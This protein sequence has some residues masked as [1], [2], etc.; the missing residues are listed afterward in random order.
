LASRAFHALVNKSTNNLTQ[1]G[2]A[3]RK[4]L[5]KASLH[6][7]DVTLAIVVFDD[8]KGEGFRHSAKKRSLDAASLVIAI[9]DL[10]ASPQTVFQLVRIHLLPPR[11]T[12]PPRAGVQDPLEVPDR[13]VMNKV[14][15]S[16]LPNMQLV[17]FCTGNDAIL[18]T[19]PS[20]A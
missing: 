19:L 15:K 8:L 1:R 7:Q 5:A 9:T 11:V 3:D 17:G 12:I 20:G 10:K 18:P 14:R 16:P 4:R 6:R 2:P 13:V